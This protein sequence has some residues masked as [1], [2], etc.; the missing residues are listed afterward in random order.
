MTIREKYNILSAQ[1][2]DDKLIDRIKILRDQCLLEQNKEYFYLCNLLI[3]DIYIEKNDLDEVLALISK[4]IAGIDMI[5]FSQIYLSY[6]ERIIYVYIHKGNF[7]I[8]YKYVFEKR[9]FIDETNRDEINRWYLEMAYVYAEMNQL[10]KAVDHLQSIINNLPSEE[11]LSLAYSNLTKLYIDQNMLELARETLNESLKVTKDEEGKI[12]CHYLFAKISLL[13]GKFDDALLLYNEILDSSGTNYLNIT[14]DYLELLM[15][16]KKYSDAENFIKRI[17]K[18]IDKIDDLNFKKEFYKNKL[19]LLLITNQIL[20]GINIIDDITNVEQ[21]ILKKDV[22][23][24]EEAYEDDKNNEVF[25]RLKTIVERIEHIISLTNIAFS[26]NNVRDLLMEFSKKIETTI[27]FDEITYVL[28]DEILP[29]FNYGNALNIYNYKKNRLYER[30]IDYDSIKNTAIELMVNSGND[31]IL[32]FS[33][34]SLPLVDLFSGQKYSD[35]EVKYLVGLGANEDDNLFLAV[36]YRTK[37][38]DITTIENSIILKIITKLLSVKLFNL[39]VQER[40]RAINFFNEKII[41][42]SNLYTIIHKNNRLFLSD[43]FASALGFKNNLLLFSDYAHKIVKADISKYQETI[44]LKTDFEVNY[45]V[46]F[47][48][49]VTLVNEKQFYYQSDDFKFSVIRINNMDDELAFNDDDFLE[50]IEEIKSHV[51]DLEYKFSLI[52][53]DAKYNNFDELKSVFGIKP[54]YLSDFTYVIILENEVNQRT[55]DKY[56]ANLSHLTI[57]RFPRDLINIDDIIKYS[58][59]SLEQGILYFTDDMYQKYLKK[60]SVNSLVNKMLENPLEIWYLLLHDYRDRPIYEVKCRINGLSNK[61]NVRE[62]LEKDISQKYQLGLFKES[63]ALL[64]PRINYFFSFNIENIETLLKANNI[65][66]GSNLHF[67]LYNYS[68]DI[69][70]IIDKLNNHGIKVYLHYALLENI[71]IKDFAS[72]GIEGIVINEGI[73][74]ELRNDIINIAKAFDLTLYT[75]YEF[76]DYD[77]CI[78]KTDELIKEL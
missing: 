73:S 64:N 10:A 9:Q 49:K 42:D 12:Y 63:L 71:N 67:C 32:D 44:N 38:L 77:K 2:Y 75:N 16:M 57:V 1:K 11:M 59:I 14:N 56:I 72:L 54:Y 55:L 61:E 45:R 68:V 53:F 13:E 41:E 74:K 21:L 5:T 46:K 39:Y 30:T 70:N 19:K 20:S 62:Y 40:N 17:E 51:N 23:V 52:R 29:F 43:N 4:D 65:K 78:Y 66:N 50:K 33:E 47:T 6:L 48:D 60:V 76:N 36:L 3:I 22:L 18:D 15:K 25:M 27:A 37:H 58:K 35:L 34:S 26:S 28:F 69:T 24:L 31:V 8:A 7:S